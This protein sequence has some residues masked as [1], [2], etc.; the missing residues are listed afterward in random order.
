MGSSSKND[1]QD[2]HQDLSKT[3]DFK[4]IYI[5]RLLFE[6]LPSKPNTETIKIALE[7]KFGEV[8]I[9]SA[10]NA[11]RSFGIKKY[12]IKY[13]DATVPAQVVMGA[14]SNFNNADID[15]F[16][17]SQ[18]WD[19]EDSDELLARCKY[20]IR[21][22][23]MMSSAMDYKDRG[24]L[25]MDWLE[26]AIGLFPDCVAVWNEPACK[27]FLADEVQSDNF[28]ENRFVNFCVNI[29]SF[30]V[31]G[32]E[33][34]VVDTFGLY[35]IG[36]PDLQY[37]F[38]GLNQDDILEHAYSLA[39]YIY[40]KNPEIKSGHTVAGIKDGVIMAPEVTWG[41]QYEDSLIQP[42][43]TVLDISAG[44]YAAGKRN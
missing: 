37:H 4:P 43:R 15:Q 12:P 41:W 23:D 30:N 21:I 34:K 42:S 20:E 31:G 35:A 22:F 6:E 39:C 2:F 19:I 3:A 7:Q 38:H 28:I 13:E 5:M 8:D 40:D 25:L 27:L 17:R 36:L 29:R 44:E 33:D 26:V 14:I 32:S 18:I 1:K 24:D 11:L 10:D 16:S 9:I